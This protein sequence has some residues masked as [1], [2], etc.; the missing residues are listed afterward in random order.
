MNNHNVIGCQT[1]SD[2]IQE[3]IR[4]NTERIMN[5]CTKESDE[6]T[7]MGFEKQLMVLV[8]QLGC[9]FF[10]YFW[11]TGMKRWIIPSG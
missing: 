9:L 4:S 8:F 3:Q 5:F 2:K 10:S 1:T 11:F 7:F 6:A